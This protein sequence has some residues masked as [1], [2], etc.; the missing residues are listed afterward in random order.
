MELDFVAQLF[1]RETECTPQVD[2]DILTYLSIYAKMHPEVDTEIYI[3]VPKAGNP[4]KVWVWR[5]DP[6]ST[7]LSK[8]KDGIEEFPVHF[9]ATM[10]TGM[11]YNGFNL[12]YTPP[13]ADAIVGGSN[14][15]DA[16]DLDGTEANMPFRL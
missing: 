15:I 1:L 11:L 6:T 3:S 16:V 14:P 5:F 10:G 13:Q 4:N 9:V 8:V 2:S 7:T 12:S